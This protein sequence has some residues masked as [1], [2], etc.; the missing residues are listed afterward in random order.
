MGRLIGQSEGGATFDAKVM[1]S[2]QRV[3]W[4]RAH[5]HP[6]PPPVTIRS[7]IDT[8]A[9]SSC[10][11]GSIVHRLGLEP[12]D[13]IEIHTPSTMGV[14]VLRNTYDISI[15]F[16]EGQ[17]DPRTYTLEIVET[18]LLDQ[19][20]LLLVGRDIL[21]RCVFHYDGPNWIFELRY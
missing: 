15:I 1:A 21:N 3:A 12:R 8:G 11:D 5:G 4:L 18:E 16:G 10:I 17:P 2:P 7:L 19:G 9:S 6:F 20:F 14:P 13:L